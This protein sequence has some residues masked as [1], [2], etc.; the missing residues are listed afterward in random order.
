L[1]VIHDA[2]VAQQ[3]LY[4]LQIDARLQQQRGEGVPIPVD[5]DLGE[6]R[7]AQRPGPF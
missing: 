3:F 1:A 7:A 2:A 6:L 4:S 5:R